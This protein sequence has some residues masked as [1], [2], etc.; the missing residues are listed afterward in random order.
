MNNYKRS[1]GRPVKINQAIINQAINLIN[2]NMTVTQVCQTL[3]IS[4]GS[5]YNVINP[6]INSYS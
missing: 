1:K 2:Q 3:K 5:F 6:R 4:R